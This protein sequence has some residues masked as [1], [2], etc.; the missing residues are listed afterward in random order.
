MD[1]T[2]KALINSLEKDTNT[3]IKWFRD[4]YLKLN[5]DKCHL[6]ISNHNKDLQINV[7]TKI[8]KCEDSVKLLGIT[9]D[10]KLNFGTHVSNLC[11]KASQKL[12]ALARISNFMSR[13]KLRILMKAFIESQ[14]GYCP[15]T[16]MF[17]SRT[18]NKRT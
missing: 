4:N 2:V 3:L 5:A 10:N 17:H 18:L 14:F 11:K 13:D 16:W 15:L 7:D 12:H 6:L 9:L 8:I 1:I